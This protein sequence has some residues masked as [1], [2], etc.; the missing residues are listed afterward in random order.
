MSETTAPTGSSVCP[1]T[2]HLFGPDHPPVYQCVTVEVF[3]NDSAP[4][5]GDGKPNIDHFYLHN[6]PLEPWGLTTR[7][8]LEQDIMDLIHAHEGTGRINRVA[9][10]VREGF[11][12][13]D[14][15]RD[16]EGWHFIDGTCADDD[17]SSEPPMPAPAPDPA[18]EPPVLEPPVLEPPTPEPTP[19]PEPV[20]APEP[21]EDP[22]ATPEPSAADTVADDHPHPL[23]VT[24][25][26]TPEQKAEIVRW[27]P[28][29]LG[30]MVTAGD[31]TER[32]ASVVR[33]LL[34]GHSAADDRTSARNSISPI[35]GG[36]P[37]DELYAHAVTFACKSISRMPGWTA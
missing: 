30:Q 33:P 19:E 1:S 4:G 6:Y 17:G 10:I 28:G 13:T 23:D 11:P 34:E 24:T 15:E 3:W 29:Y 25:E 35:L 14:D 8:K 36:S 2:K 9:F 37:S 20:P 12:L 22:P 21:S 16:A 32:K 27:L 26:L 31:I 5:K 7:R 18:P